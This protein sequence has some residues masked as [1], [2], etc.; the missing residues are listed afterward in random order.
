MKLKKTQLSRMEL[1]SEHKNTFVTI[2]GSTP[3]LKTVN[4]TEVVG[5]YLINRVFRNKAF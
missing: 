3:L 2:L 4:L 5:N 1:S